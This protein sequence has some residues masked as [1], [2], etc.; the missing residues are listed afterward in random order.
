MG[1]GRGKISG[2]GFLDEDKL[3]NDFRIPAPITKKWNCTKLD[4]KLDK[5][6]EKALDKIK[7]MNEKYNNIGGL[8]IEPIVG[9]YGVYFYRNSFMLKLR[10]LCDELGIPII[11]DEI[12]TGGG[13]TGKFFG[14]QHYQDF[15]P[16]YIT[17]GKGILLSGITR[18]IRKDHKKYP[19]PNL[20]AFGPTLYHYKDTMIR[21]YYVLK[22]IYK[23]DLIKHAENI[24]K[25]FINKLRKRAYNKK[26]KDP[27]TN[28]RG[29]GLLL[30][31]TDKCCPKYIGTGMGRIMPELTITKE[32]IDYL[33]K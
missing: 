25:Y 31:V 5:K 3:L 19:L 10:K 29:L 30:Y 12:L 14:Y 27:E 8:L 20:I 22:T 15:E 16:D 18:V 4:E 7:T 1:G 17:F 13:R 9:P 6:E 11:A 21:S 23:N 2:M 28:I 33:S 26:L 32:I 24:G